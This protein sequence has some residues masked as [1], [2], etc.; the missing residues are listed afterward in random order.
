MCLLGCDMGSSSVK[1]SVIDED[2]GEELGFGFY[3]KTEAPIAARH[4]GW[5]EQNPEDWWN[6]LKNAIK[7]AIGNAGIKGEDIKAIG[8]S[9]QMH[10]L[11]LV[12]EKQQVLCPSIIWCDSRAVSYGEHA[13]K[14][15]GEEKCLDHLLNSPGNFTASKLAWVRDYE[16]A[17]YKSAYKMMLPG[18]YIAMRMTGNIATTISGLSECILWDFKNNTLAEDLLNFYGIDKEL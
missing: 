14:C 6:Y 3:P 17:L 4:P 9:Y 16:P 11:V 10:G 12:N 8:I 13:F 18:D 2:S 1:V 7:E 5:A 15:I